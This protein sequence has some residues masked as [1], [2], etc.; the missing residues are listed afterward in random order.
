MAV[1]YDRSKTVVGS[2][3]DAMAFAEA[4]YHLGNPVT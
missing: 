4:T 3:E 1:L 2:K